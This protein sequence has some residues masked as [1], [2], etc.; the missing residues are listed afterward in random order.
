MKIY[1]LFSIYLVT[2]FFLPSLVQGIILDYY[3]IIEENGNS[4]IILS[5]SG[6][7]LVNIPIKRDVDEV[8]VQGALY[9]LNDDSIDVSIGSTEQAIVLYKTSLL[10]K[11]EEHLWTFSMNLTDYEKNQTIVAMPNNTNIKSTSPKAFIESGPFEKLIWTGDVSKISIDYYFENEIPSD[12]IEPKIKDNKKFNYTK[13]LI[14]SFT[15]IATL[16]IVTQNQKRKS[17]KIKNRENI[18]KTLSTNENKVI[19]ILLKNKGGMKRS[20]L[21]KMSGIA[22]SSL[23]STLKNLER[24][25]I[26]QLD[27]T[28][29]SH[30]V[31]L[32]KWFDEL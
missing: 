17:V 28:Y 12:F 2:L 7:G 1:K 11:K 5:I 10:T 8:K 19:G 21:E 32:T 25:K 30:Y 22:K 13:I 14:L 27:K 16:I 20:K 15:A 4:L 3:I 31:R 26:L 24:K 18:M 9:S 6:S 23:A 29:T